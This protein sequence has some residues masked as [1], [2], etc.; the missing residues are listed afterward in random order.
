MLLM[1]AGPGETDVEV[2]LRGTG[3]RYARPCGGHQDLASAGV[4]AALDAELPGDVDHSVLVEGW[5]ESGPTRTIDEDAGAGTW[6]GTGA[7]SFSMGYSRRWGELAT[8]VVML[9][10]GPTLAELSYAA[11]P[12]VRLRIGPRERVYWT[13]ELAP[14]LR[15]TVDYALRTDV[16][17]ALPRSLWGEVGL[18]AAGQDIPQPVL[19]LRYLH[20]NGF[21]VRLSGARTLDAPDWWF[22]QVGLVFQGT[23]KP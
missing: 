19:G 6:T 4:R 16:H 12:T 20:P 10:D 8:G 5:V 9:A 7:G 18:T 17:L 1:A 13:A 2:E 3:G 14:D 23:V 15:A 21:G 11:V 22:V